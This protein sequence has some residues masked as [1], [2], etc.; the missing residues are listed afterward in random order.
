MAQKPKSLNL[1]SDH[2]L[3][4]AGFIHELDVMEMFGVAWSTWEQHY[5]TRIPGKTTPN[6][7]WFHRNQL[8][9]WWSIEVSSSNDKSPRD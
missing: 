6:G 7:R 4:A 2:P 9:A 3:I 1:P 5:R 8:V